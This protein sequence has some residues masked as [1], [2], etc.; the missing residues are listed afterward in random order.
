MCKNERGANINNRNMI[1]GWCLKRDFIIFMAP[2]YNLNAQLLKNKKFSRSQLLSN[3][4]WHFL[5][6]T[7]FTSHTHFL[8]KLIR[9][10]KHFVFIEHNVF[11]PK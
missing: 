3:S 7:S 6:H 11:L 2:V 10:R 9:I 1:N 5:I 8:V 4:V